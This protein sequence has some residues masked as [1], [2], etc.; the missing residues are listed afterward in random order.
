M[1]IFVFSFILICTIASA[2]EIPMSKNDEEKRCVEYNSIL[3]IGGSYTYVSLKPK[4]FASFQG[5]LGGAQGLYEYRPLRTVY[6]GVKFS[7]R[8]GDTTQDNETRKLLDFDVHG[9]IGYT[10]APCNRLIEA[11]FYTGLGYRYLGE[12]LI[13]PGVE[14]IAFNYNEFY[15][16]V[17][18]STIWHS[19][20]SIDL[21]F[22]LI[23]MPQVYPALTTVPIGGANW[24]IERKLANFLVEVP[25]MYYFTCDHR[26]FVELKPFFEYWEDGKT[27][28]VTSFGVPLGI[29]GNTYYFVG[30]EV[31]AGL[32]F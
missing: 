11:S 5:N 2:Q 9:R 20:E 18:L 6:E 29:P 26:G 10:F 3:R 27:V 30:I 4:G 31:N 14:D 28:A 23:W 12:T 19:N 8:Q 1:K 7:Y 24:V 13:Q 16:P 21:G 17:G 32:N 25:I 22:N 15:V